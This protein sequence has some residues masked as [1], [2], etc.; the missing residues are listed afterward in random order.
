MML[1]HLIVLTA[2]MVSE[3]Q[4]RRFGF[5]RFSQE[6]EYHNALVQCNNSNILGPKPISVRAA[7]P[8]KYSRHH[9]TNYSQHK[10]RTPDLVTTELYTPQ[11]QIETPETVYPSDMNVNYTGVPVS[12]QP[13]WV[14]PMLP[15]GAALPFNYG[16]PYVYGQPSYGQPLYY[17]NCDLSSYGLIP[18]P[19]YVADGQNHYI[20]D[21]L[22]EEM[23][24]KN[25]VIV[26]IAV[27]RH[28]LCNDWIHVYAT[29]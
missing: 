4:S 23:M 24:A 13:I 26:M 15:Y 14:Y 22:N 10:G 16:D 2:V 12:G 9:N 20:D 19:I 17:Q 8:R 27:I 29:V 5:V 28:R 1:R 21:K 25:E 6:S 3:G 18:G 11:Q 7:K